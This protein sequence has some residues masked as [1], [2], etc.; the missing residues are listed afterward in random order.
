MRDYHLL[1]DEGRRRRLRHLA[2]RALDAYDLDVVRMRA[3]T[4][5][6]N[7]VFRLDTAD[8]GRFVMRVGMGPPVGH[9]PEEVASE[10]E[11]LRFIDGEAGVAVP[12]PVRCRDGGWYTSATGPDVPGERPCVVFT[13]LEGSLLAD[14]V[15]AVGL[16]PFGAAAAHLHGAASRFQPSPGFVAPRFDRIYP[17]DLPFV[18]FTDV[19]DDLLGTERRAVFEEGLDVATAALE[20]LA[21][22]GPMRVIHGDLHGW[23]VKTH[24][25]RISVFDFEDMVWG[26]P[27]QDLATALYYQWS[28]ESFDERWRETRTGYETVAPWPDRGGEIEAFIIARTLLMANDVVSQPE[29]LDVAPE[30]YERGERRIRDMLARL[31]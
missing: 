16:T 6:S 31:A 11:F 2:T 15:D 29:W 5:A 24:H 21:G 13:W 7:G 12:Q 10:L 17:Y 22:A 1:T 27:V 26:W 8:G 23:N 4:D 9:R 28:S 19:G 30:I 3:L 14:R 18:V 20:R 25:G